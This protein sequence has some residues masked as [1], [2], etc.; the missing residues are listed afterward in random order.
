YRSPTADRGPSTRLR[1]EP[2]EAVKDNHKLKARELVLIGGNDKG[3]PQQ[4]EATGPGQVDLFDSAVAAK[5][6]KNPE[7]HRPVHALWKD[8]LVSTKDREGDRVFDL[9]TFTGEAVFLDEE[10]EQELQGEKLMVWLEPHDRAAPPQ[11][12]GPAEAPGPS[13]QRPHKVEAF[14]RVKSRS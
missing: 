4:L 7:K 2:L 6:P 11:A 5:F 14:E 9:L 12:A 1:G 13:G 3:G 8:R 10:H